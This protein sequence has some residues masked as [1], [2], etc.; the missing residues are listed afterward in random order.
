MGDAQRRL[1]VDI[2]HAIR[3][4]AHKLAVADVALDQAC[5]AASHRR[6]QVLA[7]PAHEVIERDDLCRTRVQQRVDDVRADEAGATGDQDTT[8]GDF[9]GHTRAGPFC[10]MMGGKE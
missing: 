10:G 8:S 4:L 2:V 5:S 3:Q 7:L 9:I 6:L 1:V